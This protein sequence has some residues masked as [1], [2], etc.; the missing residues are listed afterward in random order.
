[1]SLMCLYCAVK[2]GLSEEDMQNMTETFLKYYKPIIARVREETDILHLGL[3]T[4]DFIISP[5]ANM[6]AINNEETAFS[7]ASQTVVVN[8]REIKVKWNTLRGVVHCDEQHCIAI[9]R[10]NYI[11]TLF[12]EYYCR[13]EKID[14][15]EI[16][17]KC[18]RDYYPSVKI[19]NDFQGLQYFTS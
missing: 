12:D 15:M 14:F 1:M 7:F 3:R 10:V 6:S 17:N 18:I 8:L 4:E 19:N 13:N 11:L 5:M 16:Y 2:T 9:N